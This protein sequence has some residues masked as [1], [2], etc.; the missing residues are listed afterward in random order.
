MVDAHEAPTTAK[1][2]RLDLRGKT[3]E[4]VADILRA[5]G[6][7]VEG[8]YRER[9]W[10]EPNI[11][12]W[13]PDADDRVQVV[14]SVQLNWRDSPRLTVVIWNGTEHTLRSGQNP[15][16][17]ESIPGRREGGWGLVNTDYLNK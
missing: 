6:Y 3:K 2:I 1:A 7:R 15:C 13:E 12:N 4:E 5:N 8:I 10:N 11:F 14:W 16:F 17:F 9:A